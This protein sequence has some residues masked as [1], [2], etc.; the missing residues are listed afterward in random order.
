MILC[1]LMYLIKYTQ[2]LDPINFF[3]ALEVSVMLSYPLV[4]FYVRYRDRKIK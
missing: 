1:D 2:D 3:Q 4:L